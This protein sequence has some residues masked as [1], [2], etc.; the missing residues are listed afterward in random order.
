MKAPFERAVDF[1][2]A[3]EDRT[4][5]GVVTVDRGGKTKWGVSQRAYP[6]LDIEALTREDAVEIFRRD[7]WLA[8]KCDRLPPPVSVLV[9]DSAINQGVGAACRLLQKAARVKVDGDIGAATLAAVW[10]DPLEVAARFVAKRVIRY[11]ETPDFSVNGEGWIT[12]TARA[13][14]AS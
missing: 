8:A 6:D 4:G 5:K 13:L 10:R 11:T 14:L 9:F 3:E 7:Y 2:L 12:R 1:V